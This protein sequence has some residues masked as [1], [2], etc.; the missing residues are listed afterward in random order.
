MATALKG[1]APT[2]ISFAD[3]KDKIDLYFGNV[4]PVPI[5]FEDPWVGGR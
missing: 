2:M 3:V 4:L 1:S 5:R